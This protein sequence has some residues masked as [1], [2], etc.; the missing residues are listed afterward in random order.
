MGM[1][2]ERCLAAK[3][4]EF[5]GDGERVDRFGFVSWPKEDMEIMQTSLGRPNS[6]EL[7]ADRIFFNNALADS[8][9]KGK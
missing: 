1:R 2:V 4:S 5:S 9:F 8:I 6:F 7:Q 3:I